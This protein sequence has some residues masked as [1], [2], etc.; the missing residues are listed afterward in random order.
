[1]ELVE[2]T[3]D[4]QTT[5]G[6]TGAPPGAS[7]STGWRRT[8]GI[9]VGLALLVGVLVTAFAWPPAESAPRDVPVAVVGPAEAMAQLERQVAEVMPNALEFQHAADVE[10]ARQLIQ[11]RDVYGA[12]VLEPTEPPRVLIASAGGPVVAQ[13]LTGIAGQ[14]AEGGGAPIRGPEVEDVVPLSGEDPRGSVFTAAALPMVLGG[15]VIGILMSFLVTGMRRRIVG[16]LIAAVAAGWVVTLVTQ[17][18]LGAIGGDAWIN[19]G[20]VGLVVTAISL[21]MIGLVAVIGPAGIGIGAVTMFLVGNSLSGVA[22]APQMLPTALGTLG[23]FLPAGA[24]GTLLRSTGYFDGAG[25][26]RPVL[27]LVAWVVAGLT[28]AVLGGRLRPASRNAL[29]G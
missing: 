10:A 16:A 3:N 5:P 26:G 24:G 20:A 8:F 19:A 6:A 18:W 23:Q 2:L 22:S 17:T 9:G 11:D 12:V 15:M 27:T 13:I 7:P 4:T 21:T 1:M 29:V 28:L 25:A 14:L